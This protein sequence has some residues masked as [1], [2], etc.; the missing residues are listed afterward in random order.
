MSNTMNEY[1][2][3]EAAVIIADYAV[4]EHPYDKNPE[5]PETFSDYNQGWHDACDYIRERLENVEN[6]DVAPVKR[7]RCSVCSGK[8]LISQDSDNGYTYEV[9]EREMQIW[10]GDECVAV[11]PIEYCPE[12]GARM[13]GG[14]DNG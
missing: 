10:N 5:K 1:I 8:Y 13:D 11:F 6:A 2:E 12:C 3:R 4:D 9:W 7:G 14:D